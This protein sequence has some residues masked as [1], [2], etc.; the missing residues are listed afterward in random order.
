MKKILCINLLLALGLNAQTLSLEQSINKTLLN[1]PDIKAFALKVKQSNAGYRSALSAYLPQINFSAEYDPS[2]TYVFPFNGTFHTQ[3]DDG[4]SAGVNLKQKIWDFSQ[5]TSKI[6]ATKIDEKIAALSLE[7]IKILIASKVK[8]L[9]EL[10]VVQHEAISVRKKDLLS[11]EAY[12]AQAKGLFMQGLKTEADTSRFLSAVYIA[13]DNLA[14][15][16]SSYEK[17]KNS[18]SLYMAE[19]LDDNVTLDASVI[20]K[21]FVQKSIKEILGAN[22]QLQIYDDTIDKNILLHKSAKAAHYGSIDLLASYDRIGSLNIYDSKKVGI[23]LNLPLYSGGKISAQAQN[24]EIGSQISQEQ[25]AS[26]LLNLKEEI[27]NL[28]LDI[29]R[30]DKTIAAKKAQLDAAKSTKK[31][32]DGRYKEGLATYI[33]VLDATTLVLNA[34]LGL[35]E[36]YYSRALSIDRIDYLQGKI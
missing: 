26:K 19:K 32:L 36:A 30:Y 12:Y 10:M 3:D 15:A 33:E 27:S 13:K 23:V 9:Y 20:K 22:K 31:V 17:A 4:W 2:K 34:R 7:D 28:I 11:K 25:K 14:I 24:M 18:L 5:T 35:L 1:H 6:N 21:S 8:S 16:K 29:K